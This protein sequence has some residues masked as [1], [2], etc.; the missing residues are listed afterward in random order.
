MGQGKLMY[1]LDIMA[2]LGKQAANGEN[3]PQPITLG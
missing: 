2:P 1:S 3:K